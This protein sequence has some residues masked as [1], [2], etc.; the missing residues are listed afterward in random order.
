MTLSALHLQ[1]GFHTSVGQ[2][3]N[4]GFN[5]R[6]T[7]ELVVFDSVDFLHR[8]NGSIRFTR[9]RFDFRFSCDARLQI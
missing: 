2:H 5:A 8:I 4:K 6:R 7:F 9:E 1:E 3:R